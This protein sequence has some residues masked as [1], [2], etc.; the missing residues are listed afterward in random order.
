MR[1]D[2]GVA[3]IIGAAAGIGAG[4]AERS[5]EAGAAVVIFDIKSERPRRMVKTLAGLAG[6]RFRRGSR[7][8]CGGTNHR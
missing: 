8:V 4:I 3:L 6:G 7:Q 5:S 2:N 1:L